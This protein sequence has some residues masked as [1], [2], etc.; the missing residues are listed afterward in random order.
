MNR[1]DYKKASRNGNGGLG[2]GGI[3]VWVCCCL[4]WIALIAALIIGIIALT[5]DPLKVGQIL[6]GK[7]G[8][9]GNGTEKCNFVY[10][11]IPTPPLLPN[12]ICDNT[13]Q[14]QVGL[15]KLDSLITNVIGHPTNFRTICLPDGKIE[16]NIKKLV[17]PDN[18]DGCY[19]A[20][21]IAGNVESECVKVQQ[22]SNGRITI[23]FIWTKGSWWFIEANNPHNNGVSFP[24]ISEC[25]SSGK[26]DK[27]PTTK[28]DCGPPA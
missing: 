11:A 8:I 12:S 5:E 10:G 22:P 1:S 4:I 9:F 19:F 27:C 2:G 17:C 20:P 21:N 28:G 23:T 3:G 14:L 18:I 16:G 6:V 24:G 15:T 26:S 13:D 25:E 7:G